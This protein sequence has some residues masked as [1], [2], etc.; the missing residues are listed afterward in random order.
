MGPLWLALIIVV[1]VIVRKLLLFGV[2]R[3]VGRG[4][5][6]GS[7]HVVREENAHCRGTD[8]SACSGWQPAGRPP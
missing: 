1:M 3:V 5:R 7:E 4:M 8:C 2:W 6:A